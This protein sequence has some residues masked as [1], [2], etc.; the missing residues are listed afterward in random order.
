MSDLNDKKLKDLIRAMVKD[1]P[2]ARVGILGTTNARTEAGK[3]TNASIGAKHEFGEE[4][5]PVRSFLRM[6]LTTQLQKHL[7]DS[8]LFT[9]AAFKEVLKQKSL[10]PWVKI[11]AVVAEGVVAEAFATGGFGQWRKSN[12]TNKKV[13]MTLIESTQLRNSITSEVK[14]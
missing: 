13:H 10:L 6:P 4:G 12:M 1:S 5:M 14:G 9:D 2:V 11:F 8:G 3:E 7:D